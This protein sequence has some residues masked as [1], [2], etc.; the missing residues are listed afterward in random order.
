MILLVLS[1]FLFLFSFSFFFHFLIPSPEGGSTN[2]K[3]LCPRCRKPLGQRNGRWGA[4]YACDLSTGCN[5]V[6]DSTRVHA[7][8][9]KFVQVI[10]EM[11]TPRKV[12]AYGLDPVASQWTKEAFGEISVGGPSFLPPSSWKTSCSMAAFSSYSIL[13]SP[14]KIAFEWNTRT[15]GVTGAVFPLEHYEEVSRYLGIWFP[16]KT[17]AFLILTKKT[18]SRAKVIVPDEDTTVFITGV[19]VSTLRFFKDHFVQLR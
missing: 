1:F 3:V 11:E 9:P 14:M 16:K 17:L 4:F 18:G 13:T 10:L 8:F 7:L 2:V 5:Y 15:D 12:R 6:I 19:P